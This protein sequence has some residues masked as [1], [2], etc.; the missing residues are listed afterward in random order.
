M[1]HFKSIRKKFED[2]GISIFAYNYSVNQS[3]TDEEIERGFDM[4]KALGVRV[5]TASTTLPLPSAWRRSPIST[6]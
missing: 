2:A 4:A 1:D 5:I 6:K 3:F